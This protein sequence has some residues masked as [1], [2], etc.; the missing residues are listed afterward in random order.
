MFEMELGRSQQHQK[1]NGAIDLEGAIEHLAH[2]IGVDASI[3]T[4]A[5]AKE[6]ARITRFQQL[7]RQHDV[8]FRR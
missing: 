6:L 5:L 1:L 8:R 4:Q 3:L 7:R 2:E